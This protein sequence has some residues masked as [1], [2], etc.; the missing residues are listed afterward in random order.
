MYSYT[1]Y[2]IFISFSDIHAD[3]LSLQRSC[4][5]RNLHR[6]HQNKS[7]TFDHP[8][9][10]SRKICKWQQRKN[11]SNQKSGEIENQNTHSVTNLMKNLSNQS[12]NAQC[13]DT[14]GAE[15]RVMKTQLNYDNPSNHCV[16]P[17]VV[18]SI[19]HPIKSVLALTCRMCKC[20]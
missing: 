10:I 12:M 16:I 18:S 20:D 6:N 7:D 2:F 4:R 9:G 19:S 8:I 5:T 13:H 15:D 17:T 11:S 1:K 14:G 3:R